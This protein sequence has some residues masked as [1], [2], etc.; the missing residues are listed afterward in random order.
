MTMMR[1]ASLDS[2]AEQAIDT[3]ETGA[4]ARKA[5]SVQRMTTTCWL[6]PVRVLHADVTKPRPCSLVPV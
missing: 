3:P 1:L 4:T 5:S 6:D 2:C